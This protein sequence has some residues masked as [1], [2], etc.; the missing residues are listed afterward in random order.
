MKL[1]ETQRYTERHI[2]LEDKPLRESLK[3]KG[4]WKLLLHTAITSYVL[5]SDSRDT[6]IQE[7]KSNGRKLMLSKTLR[8]ETVMFCL[9]VCFSLIFLFIFKNIFIIVSLRMRT[10]SFVF[11]FCH[12]LFIESKKEKEMQAQKIIISIRRH[13]SPKRRLSTQKHTH[14]RKDAIRA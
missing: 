8:E 5:F 10:P 7:D 9:S 14:E 1:I 12:Q 11:L 13:D 3:H 2:L 4:R 6:G